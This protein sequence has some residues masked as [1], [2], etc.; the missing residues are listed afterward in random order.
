MFK[1]MAVKNLSSVYLP[2]RYDMSGTVIITHTDLDGVASAALI[3]KYLRVRGVD[4]SK[5][6]ILLTQPHNLH[7]VLNK[8]SCDEL[9]ISDLGINHRTYES[10][11]NEV[12]RLRG[13]GTKIYWFDHHVWQ[14]SWINELVNLGVNLYLNPNTCSA[15]VV[16]S[17]LGLLDNESQLLANATCSVDLWVFNNYLG[18]YLSRYVVCRGG[19]KWRKYLISKLSGFNGGLDDEVLKCVEDVVD[20]DLRTYGEVL[21]KVLISVIDGVKVAFV[22]K[23]WEESSTSYIAHFIMSR[24][25]AD[26]VVVCKEGSL[27]IRSNELNIRELAVRLGGGG[28]PKAAGAPLKLPLLH[29]LLLRIGLKK[30]VLKYCAKVVTEAIKGWT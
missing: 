16:V 20:R 9:F 7:R 21:K 28:H 30:Y 18:N 29:K 13:E 24:V 14:G 17:S 12:R 27:S 8:L 15:G 4:D 10:L 23:E 26:V 5:I 3:L 6:S 1:T 19:N 2:I 25:N 22:V 11:L